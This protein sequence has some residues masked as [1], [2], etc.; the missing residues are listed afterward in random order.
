M[1]V[2]IKPAIQKHITALIIAF[3]ADKQFD[4]L[5]IFT[6]PFSSW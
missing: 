5:N 1:L 3:N 2:L 6:Y 4:F